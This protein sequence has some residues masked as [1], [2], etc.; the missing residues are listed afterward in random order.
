ME[1]M[2]K[3][4]SKD[5]SKDR[6]IFFDN[7]KGILILLVV[8]AH[9]LYDMSSDN[10]LFEAIAKVIYIFHMP[11][12]VFVSGY[13]SKNSFDKQ[14]FFRLLFYYIFVNVIMMI[15]S[16]IFLGNS[17]SILTPYYSMWY[18]LALIVWR[19]SIKHLSK[20]KGII[21]ISIV[22]ALLIGFW[23]EVNNV[24]A[25]SR[26][27]SF[28][29]LFVMG[30]KLSQETIESFLNNRKSYVYVIGLIVLAL[31]IALAI[32][33]YRHFVFSELMMDAYIN[34]YG[35]LNRLCLF[36]LAIAF[37]LGFLLFIPNKK[38]LGITHFGEKS[39]Y[40]Y[41][42]HRIIVLALPCLTF[43]EKPWLSV[44]AYLF[45]SLLI[46]ILL[47][48]E[49]IT[50]LIENT[51]QTITKIMQE[52]KNYKQVILKVICITLLIEVLLVPAFFM[53]KNSSVGYVRATRNL[54]QIPDVISGEE[55]S[56]LD[57]SFSILYAGDLI[58]LKEQVRRG[59]DSLNDSYSFDDVF[60]Y[61]RDYIKSADLSIGV[62]EGP[63]ASKEKG[64]SNSDF[65][66]GIEL[67]LNFPDEFGEAVKNAGFDLVTLANNHLLDK[68]Q[69]G[70]ER[71]IDV[72]ERIGL[73]QTGGYKTQEDKNRAK[74]I[75]KDGLRIGVLSYT[76]G[77]NYKEEDE[78]L[79][80][81]N[82]PLL[83]SKESS[84]FN[85]VKKMVKS[86]FDRLKA[87]NPDIIIVLPHMGTQFLNQVDYF[88]TTWNEIFVEYGANIILGDHAHI[89][90]PI[91]IVKNSS[92]EDVVI[93]N[94]PGNFANSYREE[95]G[96]ATAMVEV[97]LDRQTGKFN[98]LSVIPMWVQAPVLGNYR[99]IP[100]Y[101]FA[102]NDKLAKE[103]S[104]IEQKRATE[105][106]EFITETMLGYKVRLDSLQEDKIY[107]TSEGLKRSKV[108]PIKIN[109]YSKIVQEIL[110][111]NSVCFIG[112]SI[113]EGTKNGGYGW[114]E[115][116]INGFEN[117]SS[118]KVS[119]GGATSK[120]IQTVYNEDKAVADL[121]VIAI[122]TNDIR[123]RNPDIC[124]MNEKEYVS[125][126]EKLIAIIP[127]GSSARFAFIAPWLSTDADIDLCKV[128]S[129]KK[130]ELFSIYSTSLE[131][132]C[133][134]KGYVFINPN[135]IIFEH[136]NNELESKYLVD[137]IHPNATAGIRLYSEAVMNACQN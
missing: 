118:S 94:C 84:N 1:I 55:K 4:K 125:E 36:G 10:S 106:C 81:K 31:C 71:T 131:Q 39:L 103:I 89:V 65:D 64:Y 70:L 78:L 38:L 21:P 129:T 110:R 137:Y 15:F 130:M 121:Y 97:Y 126:I 44:L 107:Y 134:E 95:N 76:Y 37:I 101:S 62:F 42:F 25:I 35:L 83:V 58:L 3:I 108:E 13:F 86:D 102:N 29:P 115:P 30:Y 16:A 120:T 133:D 96:D 18:I 68:E 63:M 5:S 112:D 26:I 67:Y 100:L 114:Y 136:L 41:L 61:T 2:E 23:T 17:L 46:C 57:N 91:E 50:N 7:I 20:I 111:S 51:W 116:L 132:F 28:F 9:F 6:N 124:A 119:L 128:D 99:P 74:I 117:V 105:V 24:L 80:A 49:K 72:L 109:Q 52:E 66:D 85:K 75:E 113:T 33:T 53:I 90:Q 59:Y 34:L 40:I 60:E 92:N 22:V 8:F 73:E 104:T 123:Y 14:K 93:V 12:F 88:Q 79:K 127:N 122:G 43:F 54:N 45:I 48:F 56:K 135:N 27:I 11:A 69:Y 87:Q 47:S 19:L 82:I 77:C 32:F 98:G